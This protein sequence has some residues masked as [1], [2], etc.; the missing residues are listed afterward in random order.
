LSWLIR[1]PRKPLSGKLSNSPDKKLI[2]EEWIAGKH[3]RI[4]EGLDLL[5]NRRNGVDWHIF[6]GKTKP[7]VFLETENAIVVIEGKRTEGGP[8]TETKWMKIRHQI[9]RHIDCA[10]EI[11]GNKTV[12]GFFIVDQTKCD[13]GDPSSKWE[14]YEQ[15]T[16]SQEALCHSLP[17]RG[18]EE[19]MNIS[20]CFT[21]VTTWQQVCSEFSDFGM[22]Y[23][24]LPNT[25]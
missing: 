7:D 1:N 16:T 25:K 24:D 12:I 8:T 22:V 15:G 19:Q 13:P 10:W 23:G 4:I 9:L 11:R 18:P 3:E 5:R 6:E 14:E 20:R 17:H 21:G 2:R